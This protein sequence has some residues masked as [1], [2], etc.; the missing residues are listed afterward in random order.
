MLSREL[1]KRG[2]G[3]AVAEAALDEVF[4]EID[5]EAVVLDLLRSRRDRYRGLDRQKALSRMY[6]FLGRR[7][8]EASVAR[9]AAERAWAEF[10]EEDEAWEGS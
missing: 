9:E 3:E 5:P 7:G 10:G 4:A 8:F 6:G 2:I 1:R